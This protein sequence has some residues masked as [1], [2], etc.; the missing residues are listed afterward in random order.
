MEKVCSPL[1]TIGLSPPHPELPTPVVS[2]SK[3]RLSALGGKG[4]PTHLRYVPIIFNF[5][6]VMNLHWLRKQ[7]NCITC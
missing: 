5:Q 2:T 7:G 6:R 4:G 3:L 1:K